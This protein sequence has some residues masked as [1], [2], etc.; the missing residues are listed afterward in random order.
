MSANPIPQFG[1][2]FNPG[3]LW[4]MQAPPVT[5]RCPWFPR[6]RKD[7][8]LSLLLYFYYSVLRIACE[9]PA[10]A[11]RSLCVRDAI[12]GPT[13][14]PSPTYRL[15]LHILRPISCSPRGQNRLP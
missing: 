7:F 6:E 9:C 1:Q 11:R 12:A 8:F 4:L 13:D 10:T 5:C 2:H 3:G 15:A 14:G